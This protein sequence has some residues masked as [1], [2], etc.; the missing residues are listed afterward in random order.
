MAGFADP[1]AA[2]FNVR[3]RLVDFRKQTLESSVFAR[4]ERGTQPLLLPEKVPAQGVFGRNG[5]LRRHG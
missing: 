1:V 3:E 4:A 5:C 2:I